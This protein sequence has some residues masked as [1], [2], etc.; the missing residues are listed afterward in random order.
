MAPSEEI[1]PAPE[2]IAGPPKQAAW[3]RLLPVLALVAAVWF[4]VI[5]LGNAQWQAQIARGQT[6]QLK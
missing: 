1:Q 3:R 5:W 4:G 2:A 6:Q